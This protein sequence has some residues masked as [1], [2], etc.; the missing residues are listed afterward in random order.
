V[1]RI[2][3]AH[4]GTVSVQSSAAQGTTFSIRLPRHA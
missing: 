2:V 4:G 1:D 3:A